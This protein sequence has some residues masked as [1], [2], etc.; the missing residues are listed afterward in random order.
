M[1]SVAQKESITPRV[2]LLDLKLQY[3]EIEAEVMMAIR[4]VC[5][6]QEFILGARVEEL[7][8]RVA[9]YSQCKYGITS[10][11]LLSLKYRVAFGLALRYRS[12]WP[13]STSI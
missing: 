1:R 2:P 3:Q 11:R 5:A 10:V 12:K 9:E 4:E 8:E 13:A 6:S 7:E